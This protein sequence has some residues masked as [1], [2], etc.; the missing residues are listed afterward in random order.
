MVVHEAQKVFALIKRPLFRPELPQ[1]RVGDL[2]KV[3]AVKGGVEPLVA[4]V[5]GGAVQHHRIDNPL[6]IP[7]DYLP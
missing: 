7:V 3:F 2:E 4:L 1:Q 6:V 5:V